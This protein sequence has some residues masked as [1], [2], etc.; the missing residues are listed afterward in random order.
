MRRLL[1]SCC[2]MTIAT[3]AWAQTCVVNDPTG[4]PLNV[5]T[6]PNGAILGALYN[7]VR[8]QIMD[9]AYDGS[10]KRWAYVVPL[11]AGKRGWVFRAFLACE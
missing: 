1:L 11:D 7:G 8:V 9:T 3:S 2:L 4:T 6:E 5:R 10:G